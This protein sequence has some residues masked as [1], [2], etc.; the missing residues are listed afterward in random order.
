M[1]KSILLIVTLYLL[2]CATT[3][4]PK[5]VQHI[6]GSVFK[7]TDHGYYTTELVMR[8]K[9]P[10]VGKNKADLI[11]HDYEATDTP[12]LNITA[13]PYLTNKGITSKEK[14]IVKDA[15]RGL[16]LIEN[17]YFHTH[18][19]WELRLKIRGPEMDDTVVLPLPEINPVR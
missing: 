9:Q 17:I 14:P 5:M 18:G 16:Y 11:I 15:G 6:K 1:K 8:P 19:K 2:S 7:A 13:I 10:V 4:T 12:G 3:Y